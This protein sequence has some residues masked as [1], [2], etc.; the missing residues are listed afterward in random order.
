MDWIKHIHIVSP[1]SFYKVT[2]NFNIL[3]MELFEAHLD[4]FYHLVLVALKVDSEFCKFRHEPYVTNFDV[5]VDEVCVLAS[6][7]LHFNELVLKTVN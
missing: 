3:S 6:F 5:V 2:D 4:I 1:A 7:S